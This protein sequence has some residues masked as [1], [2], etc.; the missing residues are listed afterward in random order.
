M[1]SELR[2][3]GLA[4]VEEKPVPVVY[5][6]VQLESL[7]FLARLLVCSVSSVPPCFK[8]SHS[9]QLAVLERSVTKWRGSAWSLSMFTSTGGAAKLISTEALIETTGGEI[10]KTDE[11]KVTVKVGS[12]GQLNEDLA[13]RIAVLNPISNSLVK[14][15]VSGSAFDQICRDC[16]VQLV[17]SVK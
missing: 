5:D 3:R 11:G 10:R 17:S 6:D 7:S 4:V 13:S 9:E 15:H 16:N 14:C 8:I 12:E 1:A 2:K